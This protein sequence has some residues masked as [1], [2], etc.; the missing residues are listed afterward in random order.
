MFSSNYAPDE[1]SRQFI[2]APDGKSSHGGTYKGQTLTLVPVLDIRFFVPPQPKGSESSPRYKYF[3]FP[4]N[5]C[6]NESVA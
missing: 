6:K 2:S 3:C 5:L 1:N 4:Y